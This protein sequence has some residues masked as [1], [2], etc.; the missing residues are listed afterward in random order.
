MNTFDAA[1]TRQSGG[2]LDGTFDMG[3][4]HLDIKD[5][6]IRG[7]AQSF[8]IFGTDVVSQDNCN[9]EAQAVIVGTAATGGVLTGNLALE[10]TKNIS[11]SGCTQDQINGYPGTGAVFT[12]TAAMTPATSQ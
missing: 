10:F 8:T 4:L 7:D 11:G 12:Y 2:T 1:I 3:S 9:V 6:Q 5:G